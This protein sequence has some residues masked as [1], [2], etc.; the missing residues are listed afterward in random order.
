MRI[1]C[2]SDTHNQHDA[3]SLPQGD[4][5]IHAGDFCGLGR[6]PEIESFAA[7]LAKQP[8]AHK[9]V[10]AGNHDKLFEKDNALARACL[11]RY[12]PK[13][14]YLQDSGVEIDGVKFWGSPWQP[15]FCGWAF[16]LPRGPELARKWKAIPSDTHVLITHGPPYG[17]LDLTS[18]GEHVGSEELMREL[19]LRLTPKV[20]VFGHI[21]EG[22]GTFTSRGTKFINACSCTE[23]YEPTNAPVV[24]DI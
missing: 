13:A 8:F 17:I 16:N 23:F 14:H 18:R 22:Y 5:L 20:H 12:C 10:I 9:V 4:V 21:H 24:V 19:D 15:E 7:W 6:T 2:I 11:R 3:L 1:V